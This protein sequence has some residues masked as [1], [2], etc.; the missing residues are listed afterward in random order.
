M[1]TE[2]EM[3]SVN[4]LPVGLPSEIGRRAGVVG[5]GERKKEK[6][7]RYSS[8]EGKNRKRWF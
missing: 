8:R 6:G 2:N 5:R 3:G 7:S 4:E 1:Y